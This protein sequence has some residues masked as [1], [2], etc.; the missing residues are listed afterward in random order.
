M[1]VCQVGKRC[2]RPYHGRLD[3]IT[4]DG[5]RVALTTDARGRA[6]LDIPAGTYRLAAARAHP[7]PRLS[8]AI[9]AGRSIRAVDGR[10]VLQ[11]RAVR[12]QTVTLLFDTGIR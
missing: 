4:A 1:G 7:L 11:V 12:T 5:N 3:L 2:E 10:L 9:V 6:A 8:S